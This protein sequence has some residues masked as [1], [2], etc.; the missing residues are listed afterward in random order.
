MGF[1]KVSHACVY[2][3]YEIGGAG[4]GERGG[5]VY[6]V[7]EAQVEQLTGGKVL[8]ESATLSVLRIDRA[9]PPIWLPEGL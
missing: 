7:V 6:L 4:R 1:P 8:A 2:M 9:L 3:Q 5:G